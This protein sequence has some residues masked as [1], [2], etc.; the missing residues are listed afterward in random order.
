MKILLILPHLRTGGGQQLAVDEAIGLK[1]MGCSVK[2]ICLSNKEKTIF[3]SKANENNLK[4]EYLEKNDGFSFNI[5]YKLI[6]CIKKEKPQVVHTHLRALPYTIIAS[7]FFNKIKFY[8]TVHSVAEKEATGI[9]RK[10]SCFVYKTRKF[11][12]IAISDYCSETIRDLYN[13][14]KD[15][16]PV[17]YNGID[18]ER[19]KSNIPYDKRYS[20]KIVFIS[21]GRFQKVKRHDLMIK[22]FSNVH[23]QYPNTELVLLGDGELREDIQ[24]LIHRNGLENAVVLKGIVND[25]QNE[26]NKAHVYLL[27]SDW[28]GLPLSVLEAMSCGLPVVATK[29]GGTIDIINETVGILCDVNDEQAIISAMKK[30]LSDYKYRESLFSNAMQEAQKYS[31][32]RC[33]EEY[34]KLF[35]NHLKDN[36]EKEDA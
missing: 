4:I 1:N 5:I 34:Y 20:D 17:I 8:H 11:T 26:L 7:L 15:S 12:P 14:K 35:V 18:I 33:V 10:L 2:I 22:A 30:M 19:F 3:A 31:I 9:M 24:D 25:V 36:K 32:S 29:A 23:N 21:T 16:I 13:L 28:E 27:C 6:K